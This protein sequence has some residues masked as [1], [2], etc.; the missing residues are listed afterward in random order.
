M[1]GPDWWEGCSEVQQLDLV[2]YLRCVYLESDTAVA[3]LSSA[4]GLSESRML[5]NEEM[6]ATRLLLER[7]GANGRLLNHAVVHPGVDGEIESMLE[8]RDRIGPVGWKVYTIGA[9]DADD[10]GAIDGWYL[11]DDIGEE[12]LEQVSTSGVP[13]VCAH[14]GVSGLVPTGSP[15]DF[16]PAASRH[17]DI[18]FIAYH[19]GFEP[20]TGRA[21]GARP[22]RVPSP[23]RPPTSG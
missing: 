18:S 10:V 15:R 19:S 3:V 4:P 1:Y 21:D 9:T 14:K 20:G 23:R 8:V 5:F 6:A 13:I 22:A 2:E 16:G 12:F 17:P 7:L 11:D